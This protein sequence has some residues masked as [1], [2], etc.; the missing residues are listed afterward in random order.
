M[1][2]LLAVGEGWASNQGKPVAGSR[3]SLLGTEASPLSEVRRFSSQAFDKDFGRVGCDRCF[4][5]L[6]S[7]QQIAWQCHSVHRYVD[8]FELFQ[9]GRG[10]ASFS[11]FARVL[12]EALVL[13]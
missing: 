11:G 13:L 8:K 1:F 10:I 2:A 9:S 6:V 12:I 4:R 5:G 3:H 7:F